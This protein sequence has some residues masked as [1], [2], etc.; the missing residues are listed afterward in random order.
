[1]MGGMRKG[2]HKEVARAAA[3]HEDGGWREEDCDLSNEGTSSAGRK[4]G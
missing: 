3:D 4:S 1:M 2:V